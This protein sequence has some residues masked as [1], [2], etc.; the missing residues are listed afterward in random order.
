[1]VEIGSLSFT[2]NTKK[3]F[4]FFSNTST[5]K[6][7]NANFVFL[8][9]SFWILKLCCSC[10]EYDNSQQFLT[11]SSIGTKPTHKCMDLQRS[12]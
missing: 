8:L 1:M 3:H 10:S 6:K 5:L 7:R 4:N 11:Y 12:G 2:F 9:K